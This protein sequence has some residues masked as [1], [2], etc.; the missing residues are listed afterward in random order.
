MKHLEANTGLVYLK[1]VKNGIPQELRPAFAHCAKLTQDHYEN[2]PVAS[3]LMPAD[4]RPHICSIYA[5]ARTADDFADEPGM[6]DEERISRLED[7][8]RRL[9]DCADRPDGRI[10]EAL[11]ETIRQYQIPLS[12]FEALI[13]AFSQDVRQSRHETFADLLD[14]S[15]RS[16]NPV[17]RLILILFGYKADD[18]LQQSDAIC[19]A[20]QLTNFWQDISVD[21]GRNRIYLPRQEMDRFGV[22][23]DDLEKAV[24]TD[25][26]RAM[27]GDLIERTRELFTKGKDLPEN[28]R[29]RLK[30]ELRLT[31]LGG[32]QI[33]N[34][35]EDVDCDIF[36]R[37]P[38]LS[39]STG[40][41]LLWRS[42]RPVGTIH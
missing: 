35:I 37:R 29:G 18:L 1:A 20:L 4:I 9:H 13:D 33:L 24:L 15:T 25:G 39:K 34:E 11:A 14:Y 3:W 28:V 32:A 2:F 5:F 7:W 12:L 26:F 36:R 8:R 10:F 40:C 6:G 21:Y 42:L 41:R 31:W 22:T 19:T 23:E 38:A 17:G 27:V 30:Y 16:A